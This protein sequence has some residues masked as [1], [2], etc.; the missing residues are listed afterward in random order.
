MPY[1]RKRWWRPHWRRNYRRLWTRRIRGP[2]RRKRWR[3]RRHRV[4]RKLRSIILREFQPSHIKKLTIRGLYCLF[5]ANHKR[6]NKN[7]AQYEATITR[8]GLP[9]G[10]GYSILRFNFE[11]LY[12]QHQLVHNMWS[13][14]NKYTPL[15]RYLGCSIKIYRPEIVD[16]VVK[17]QTCYPMS[18]SQFLYTGTQPSVMM[19]SRGCKRIPSK[20]TKPY[21]KPYRKYRLPPPQQMKNQWYFMSQLVKTGFVLIQSC[22][23][24]FDQY[25]ISHSAESQTISFETL[26]TKLFQ[27]MNFKSLPTSGYSPKDN[28]TMWGMTNGTDQWG[29]MIFLGNTIEYQL[30]H[31]LNQ[32]KDEMT[33]TPKTWGEVVEKYLSNRKYWGNPFHEHYISK[34][35]N[36]WYST[37]TAALTLQGKDFNT[38]VAPTT[39]L[40]TLDQEFIFQCRYNPNIDKGDTCR[41][42]LKSNWKENEDLLPP[43]DKDLE[44]DGFPLWLSAFGFVDYQIKLGKVTSV[45]THYTVIFQN[46]YV[47]P[48]LDYYLPLDTYFT[49]GNSEY[50]QGLTG[51]DRTNWYPMVTHQD[52]SLETIAQCGPGMAKLGKNTTDECKCEYKF[53]FKVGGCAPPIEKIKNPSE[54]PTY[55]IPNNFLEQPSLQSPEEPIETFLYNFDW[56]RDQLTE[57]ATQ[58]II[59]DYS[60]TKPLL[61]DSTTTGTDVPVHQTHQKEFLQT[62][63]TETETEALFQQLFHQQQQQQQLR[64]RIKQ[65]LNKLQKLE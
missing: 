2:F 12:E 49:T 20:K 1:Y 30:G 27:N 35:V 60:I 16:A 34:K 53:Y 14:S 4:R 39:G 42:Y 26:N 9:G 54:Q 65:L 32:L 13:T 50:L 21:G 18:A 56:R 43:T 6:L 46:S 25:Y 31:S 7:F 41:F 62:E 15:F 22:A 45:P 61:S 24:S 48:K 17:F 5:Q 19:M 40:T 23:A 37:K 58:R 8:E 11:S 33:T 64:Y 44:I 38:K 63:E 51:W 55:P 3:R 10:G 57:T 36:L 59:T 28:A 29:N 47:Q 52:D